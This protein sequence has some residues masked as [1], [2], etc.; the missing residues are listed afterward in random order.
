MPKEHCK[1][2]ELLERQVDDFRVIIK[3]MREQLADAHKKILAMAGDAA[4]RYNSL[5]LQASVGNSGS[6]FDEGDVYDNDD[7]DMTTS[8]DVEA[9]LSLARNNL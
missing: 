1:T 9:I 2:C 5:R 3:E 6:S 4:D 7:D 8:S